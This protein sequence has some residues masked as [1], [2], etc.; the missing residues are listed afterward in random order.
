MRLLQLL[1]VIAILGLI[2]GAFLGGGSYLLVR[3]VPMIVEGRQ[4]RSWPT[5]TG[6]VKESAA[7]SKPIVSSYRRG[8]VGTHVVE[9]RYEFAVAGKTFVGTRQSLDDVGIIKSEELAASEAGG[10]PPGSTVR[11]S[12]DADDPTR[13]M[14]TPGVPTS[15]VIG[16]AIGLLLIAGGV[17]LTIAG[18]HLRSRHAKRRAR[19]GA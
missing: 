9:L 7:V 13:S 5:T 4:S 17:G 3:N 8:T 18:F 6:T 11:V 16:S 1:I 15:S 19:R 10:M 14:L 2:F 12:Y